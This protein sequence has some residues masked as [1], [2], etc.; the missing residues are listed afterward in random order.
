MYG[1]EYDEKEVECFFVLSLLLGCA[2]CGEAVP[3]SSALPYESAVQS[4]QTEESAA[5]QSSEQESSA[6]SEPVYDV[7]TGRQ[8]SLSEIRY[9][10]ADSD[11]QA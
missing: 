11:I 5:A 1:R 10:Y 9:D 4:G 2:G 3:D 6:S 7:Q 8:L